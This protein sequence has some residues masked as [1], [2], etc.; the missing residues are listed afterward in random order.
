MEQLYPT[1]RR[2]EY[3]IAFRSLRA[4]KNLAAGLIILCLLLQIGSTI[5]VHF[6]RLLDEPAAAAP[7]AETAPATQPAKTADAEQYDVPAI[8]RLVMEHGLPIAQFASMVL[9]LLLV[10]MVM[11]AVKISLI[12]RIGGVGGF[13]GSF[14]WSLILLMMLIP[15]RPIM[16]GDMFCGA[17]FNFDE[18]MAAQKLMCQAPDQIAQ[19]FFYARFI[20]Y[21]CAALLACLFVQGKFAK[22]YAAVDFHLGESTAV[23][24]AN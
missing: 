12:E 9:C 4:S 20:A 16:G 5:A 1:A 11:F 19:G 17:M 13:M 3:A 2:P 14:N 8:A 21:P 23:N 24:K 22:G 10:L 7:V 18:L 6:A 15:W